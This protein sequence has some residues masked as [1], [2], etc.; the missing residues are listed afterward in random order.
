MFDREDIQRAFENCLKNKRSTSGAK[1]FLELDVSEELDQLTREITEG[2]YEIL[3]SKCFVIFDP[4]PREIFAAQFRD[5]IVHH[6]IIDELYPY[7]EA[8]FI[9]D[10]YSCM[11]GR[12]THY[13]QLRIYEKMRSITNDWTEEGYVLKMDLSKFFLNIP[14][15]PLA[16]ALDEWIVNRY[17]PGDPD[18]VSQ[19]RWLVN[20]IIMNRPQVGCNIVSPLWKWDVLGPERSMFNQDEFHGLAIGNLTSQFFANFYLG[21][22]DYH[23]TQDLGVG[24]WYGRYMDDFICLSKSREHLKYVA[25][26]VRKWCPKQ[27]GIKINLDK[28]YLQSIHHGVKFIGVDIKPGRIYCGER[29]I[30]N[31]KTYLRNGGTQKEVINSYLGNLGHY[32]SWNIRKKIKEDYPNLNWSDNLLKIS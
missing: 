25:R 29:T 23:I 5:R 27:L 18:K 14:I 2:T 15:I 22:L 4:K 16:K 31:F 32:S 11:N 30:K 3:P 6:L 9:Q 20:K 17:N 1:K 28:L 8:D 26:D 24:N 10:C 21:Y 12:G 19:V 7:F 13:G